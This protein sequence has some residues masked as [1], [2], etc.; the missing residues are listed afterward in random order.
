MIIYA[1]HHYV[2]NQKTKH[3]SELNKIRLQAADDFHDHVG[4]TL[5][6]ISLFTELLKK[7]LSIEQKKTI[8]Y[9]DKISSASSNLYNEAKDFIW[10]LDPN[11]DTVYELAVH[12]K[13]FGEDFFSRTGISFNSDEI[14]EELNKLK[15]SMQ[16]K[17]ELIFVFKELM[18]NA[19]KYSK[20]ENVFLNI[21][22]KNN[23]LYLEFKD[24]GVGFTI[25]D[26]S[27]GRGISSIRNRIQ[28]LGFKIN[29]ESELNKGTSISISSQL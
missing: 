4:H 28:K 19:L 1:A 16:I 14:F 2:V 15:I 22:K 12:L 21:Y 5:T 25:E 20:A 29:F 13:D 10:S 17:R 23:I 27:I 7:N 6:R 26:L 8:E 3:L 9:V 18:N 24:D 11:N